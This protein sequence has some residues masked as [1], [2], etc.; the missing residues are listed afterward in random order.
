MNWK[1]VAVLV[2]LVLA[3]AVGGYQMKAH[4]QQRYPPSCNVLIPAEWGKYRGMSTG[5]GMVF[6][7][8]DGN[9]RIVGNL[10]CGIDPQQVATP[11]VDVL[12][13]RK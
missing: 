4:A 10:P 1:R 3:S 6:E 12:I 8:K 7:D 9:L 5:S 11:R 2:V 13:R